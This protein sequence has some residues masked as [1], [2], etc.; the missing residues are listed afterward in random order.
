MAMVELSE[1]A[2]RDY[3]AVP[4]GMKGRIQAVILR[5]EKWPAVSGAKPLVR[6]LK[7]HYRIRAGDWRVVFH[8]RGELVTVDR[9]DNRRDVYQ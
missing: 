8:I 4:L 9:I 2:L 3:A 1:S 7:G 5:L 6:E